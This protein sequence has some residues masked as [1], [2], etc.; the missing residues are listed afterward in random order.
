MSTEERD[1]A[2]QQHIIVRKVTTTMNVDLII[3]RIRT[4]GVAIVRTETGHTTTMAMDRTIT[5]NAMT[6]AGTTIME[7][8]IALTTTAT[9]I[10]VIKTV[11]MVTGIV[12]MATIVHNIIMVAN[13]AHTTAR[14]IAAILTM[15]RIR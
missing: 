1:D 11:I 12:T 13:N 6:I 14:F 10:M 2:Q 3:A 5:S 4:T 8:E 7:E 15:E 9:I